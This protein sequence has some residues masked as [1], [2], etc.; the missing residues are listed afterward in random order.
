MCGTVYIYII[1]RVSFRYA[2]GNR[3]TWHVYICIRIYIYTYIYSTLYT[4]YAFT[5]T[6]TS[7]YTNTYTCTCTMYMYI[8]IHRYIHIYIHIYIYIYMYRF[9]YSHLIIPNSASFFRFSIGHPAGLRSGFTLQRFLQLAHTPRHFG[10]WKLKTVGIRTWLVDW[11]TNGLLKSKENLEMTGKSMGSAVKHWRNVRE[12]HRFLTDKRE[13]WWSN[14]VKMMRPHIVS[15][16]GSPCLKSFDFYT[17]DLQFHSCF[18][19][20]VFS[21]TNFSIP[22]KFAGVQTFWDIVIGRYILI[23][24][25]HEDLHQF[26][27]YFDIFLIPLSWTL[28]PCLALP[29]FLFDRVMFGSQPREAETWLSGAFWVLGCGETWLGVSPAEP[30]K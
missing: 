3:Y 4:V 7:T 5:S 9:R 29:P 10:V 6:Y 18:M 27:P 1:F 26:S 17:A 30:N 14:K 12:L 19:K 23:I 22:S 8:Y 13:Q 21:I 15:S 25:I 16:M 20:L 24:V 2:F 28:R 11:L